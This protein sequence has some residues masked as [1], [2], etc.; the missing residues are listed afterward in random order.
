MWSGT[1]CA[2]WALSRT[3]STR[4]AS[5]STTARWVLLLPLGKES[6][7]EGFQRGGNRTQQPNCRLGGRACTALLQAGAQ[8]R[9]C[10]PPHQAPPAGNP[11]P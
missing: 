6:L 7:E 10:G 9:A 8:W 3:S 1:C 5:S 2:R 4:T 11:L